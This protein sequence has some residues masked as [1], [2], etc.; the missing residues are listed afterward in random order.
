MLNNVRLIGRLAVE[1]RVMPFRKGTARML[2]LTVYT[3]NEYR[4]GRG[5]LVKMDPTRHRVLSF[6]SDII[7][8]IVKQNLKVGQIIEVSARI[9]N[10]KYVDGTSGK[11]RYEVQIVMDDDGV[12]FAH[13]SAAPQ[14]SA[15][16]AHRFG[17]GRP[18][19]APPAE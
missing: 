2:T 13:A 1:P 9:E 12:H 15:P 6:D 16:A 8:R 3:H 19:A 14:G 7:D 10:S 18:L 4:N 17:P 5:E 11:P